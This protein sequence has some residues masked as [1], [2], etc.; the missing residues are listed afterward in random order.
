MGD[1]GGDHGG[2]PRSASSKRETDRG[3][4]GLRTHSDMTARLDANAHLHLD[5][6]VDLDRC[7]Q[8]L[9][10]YAAVATNFRNRPL[11]LG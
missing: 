9:L 2:V 10:F 5:A 7:F 6:H 3:T 4:G 8:R 1:H 11:L